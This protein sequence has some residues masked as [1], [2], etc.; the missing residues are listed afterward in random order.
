[1]KSIWMRKRDSKREL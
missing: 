1:M